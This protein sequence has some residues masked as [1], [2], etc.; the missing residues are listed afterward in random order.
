MAASKS[1][2][3]IA[4]W[5]LLLTT[6]TTSC[7]DREASADVGPLPVA[8]TAYPTGPASEGTGVAAVSED[9]QALTIHIVDG[10][11]D[12]DVYDIQL[13]PV[14]IEILAGDAQPA[15]AIDGLL[16]P[17]TLEA[18]GTTVIG[19]SPSLAGSYTMRL[20]DGAT[21]VATLNVRNAGAR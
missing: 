10:R 2:H 14:R 1:L 13:R 16:Q 17:H 18:D 3:S 15:F 5:L 6:L 21:D 4:G 19:L 11:F 7:A 12:S 20:S 9:I 8:P